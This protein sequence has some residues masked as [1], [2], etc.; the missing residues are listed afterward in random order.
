MKI[1]GSSGSNIN[2]VEQRSNSLEQLKKEAKQNAPIQDRYEQKISNVSYVA[3]TQ[4]NESLGALEVAT[5]AIDELQQGSQKLQNL[6]QK[7][8]HFS[9]QKVEIE[10][11]F[12]AT[13]EGMLDIVD[14]TLFGQ[15]QLF[16]TPMQLNAG[17]EEFS[18]T[19]GADFGIEDFDLESQEQL[20][21]FE[22]NLSE[23][24]QNIAKAKQHVEVGSFNTLAS[25]DMTNSY[26]LE[27]ISQNLFQAQK[28][29]EPLAKGEISRAHQVDSLKEKV[30]LL[31]GE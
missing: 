3:L 9:E 5:K 29:T 10:E 25:M 2:F 16:Y 27:S 11:E 12:E 21:A 15:S 6:I 24:K 14:N 19:L 28:P 13:S 7:S 31:L 1:N 8:T 22:Q 17:K 23:I 30:S 26:Q 18:F 4:S 20:K